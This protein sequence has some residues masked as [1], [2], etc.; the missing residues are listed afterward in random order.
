[1]E[2][3]A[4]CDIRTVGGTIKDGLPLDVP[5]RWHMPDSQCVSYYFPTEQAARAYAQ[6]QQE[7][8]DNRGDSLMVLVDCSPALK[9]YFGP[10]EVRCWYGPYYVWTSQGLGY[11]EALEHG[12]YLIRWDNDWTKELDWLP[13]AECQ[14][15]QWDDLDCRRQLKRKDRASAH[16]AKR[17]RPCPKQL[18]ERTDRSGP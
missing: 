5:D 2:N 9:T 3:P 17:S 1:M 6:R 15:I 8:S 10:F 7:I 11:A 14:H 13:V 16:L 18:A 4:K 12:R